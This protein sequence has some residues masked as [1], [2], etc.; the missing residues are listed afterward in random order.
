[1]PK[2][3]TTDAMLARILVK[4]SKQSRQLAVIKRQLRAVTD[5][6]ARLRKLEQFRYLV[7]GASLA[8]SALGTWLGAMAVHR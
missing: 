3:S 5:H 1:M 8:S 4:Q 7:V 6:E 2:P